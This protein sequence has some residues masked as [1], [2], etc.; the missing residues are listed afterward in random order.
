MSSSYHYSTDAPVCPYCDHSQGHDGGFFY[1]EDLT[2][3]DCDHCGEKF[4]IEVYHSTSWT[5][6]P[7]D[8]QSPASE[9]KGGKRWVI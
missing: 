7:L 6:T 3:H 8:A 1:D 2:E 9:M 5:T 4:N